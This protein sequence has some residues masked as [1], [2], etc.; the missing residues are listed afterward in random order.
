MRQDVR[1]TVNSASFCVSSSVSRGARWHG[2]RRLIRGAGRDAR[3]TRGARG[4][5]LRAL[6]THVLSNKSQLQAFETGKGSPSV[7]TARRIDGTLCLRGA[8]AAITAQQTEFGG[9]ATAG[10]EYARP[11]HVPW[12]L[13][14]I[15]GAT[16][17][18]TRS[19]FVVR[20]SCPL[21]LSRPRCAG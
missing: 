20:D 12:I 19:G 15:V 7:D 14:V 6:A 9:S 5:S 10:L 11:G 8:I 3:T 1:C 21:P 16:T 18:L 13:R 4:P 2:T 17:S